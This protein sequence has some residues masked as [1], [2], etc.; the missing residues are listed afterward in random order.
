MKFLFCNR[1]TGEARGYFNCCFYIQ[2]VALGCPF[3]SLCPLLILISVTKKCHETHA[4]PT[5][6]MSQP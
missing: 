4:V 6:S 2:N 3:V 1:R 5:D